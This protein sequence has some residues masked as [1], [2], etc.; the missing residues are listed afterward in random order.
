VPTN[1]QFD[2]LSADPPDG[3]ESLVWRLAYGLARDHRDGVDGRCVICHAPWPCPSRYLAEA[4]FAK[5]LDEEPDENAG[6][7]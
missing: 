4:G 6:A 1:R 3:A 5:A 7:Y 2:D